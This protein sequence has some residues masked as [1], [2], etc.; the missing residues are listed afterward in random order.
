MTHEA[1]GKNSSGTHHAH[2]DAGVCI[3]HV[4]PCGNEFSVLAVFS[5]CVCW[6][7]R[8]V[9]LKPDA[10]GIMFL[11]IAFLVSPRGLPVLAAGLVGKLN[12]AKYFLRS[13]IVS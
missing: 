8:F 10:G 1:F 7:D 12:C 13:F 4:H 5:A 11:I 3:L 9:H 6:R 2:T